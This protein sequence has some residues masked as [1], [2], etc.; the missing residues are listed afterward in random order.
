[1]APPAHVVQVRVA[2]IAR[3]LVDG[4]G[5]AAIVQSVAK[6]QIKEAAERA[7]ARAAGADDEREVA[8]LVPY[9]WGDKPL[10]LRTVDMYIARAKDML[11]NEGARVVKHRDYVLAIQLAR[12]NETYMAAFKAGRYHT[13]LGV[14]KEVNKLFGLYEAVKLMLLAD[15]RAAS[16]DRE[17]R[18]GV[19]LTTDEGRAHALARV[20]EQA[21]QTDPKVRA[22]FTRFAQLERVERMDKPPS[23]LPDDKGEPTKDAKRKNDKNGNGNGKR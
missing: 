6:G 10:P 18:A 21:S 1:V 11:S 4:L 9:V 13:C 5:R 22:I 15:A 2:T 14:I 7:K 20:V 17:S 19:N 16:G 8:A 23:A 3:A 12:M